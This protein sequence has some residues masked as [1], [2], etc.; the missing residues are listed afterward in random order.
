M[1]ESKK[2]FISLS[3]SLI[4]TKIQIDSCC[5]YQYLVDSPYL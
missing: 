3:V 2:E 5:F 1:K 4:A